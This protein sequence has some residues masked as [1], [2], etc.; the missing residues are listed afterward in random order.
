MMDDDSRFIEWLRTE[1]PFSDWDEGYGNRMTDDARGLLAEIDALRA[2]ATLWRD[3]VGQ[4]QAVHDTWAIMEDEAKTFFGDVAA[5]RSENAALKKKWES[6]PWAALYD[7]S[8]AHNRYD[9]ERWYD[10]NAPKEA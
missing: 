5:L 3:H 10:A 6:V 2:D 7:P 1:P 9:I 4:R 8:E